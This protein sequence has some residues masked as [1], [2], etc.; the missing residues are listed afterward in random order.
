M[1]HIREATH[2][3]NMDYGHGDEGA[4]LEVVKGKNSRGEEEISFCRD[5]NH[6]HAWHCHSLPITD[7]RILGIRSINALKRS[8]KGLANAGVCGERSESE[9]APR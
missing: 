4:W 3:A 7:R 6:V 8:K 5:D 2:L 9:Q 1:P